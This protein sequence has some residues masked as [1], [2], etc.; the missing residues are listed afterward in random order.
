MVTLSDDGTMEFRFYRPDATEM[1]VV[2]DFNGWHRGALP[3]T[4]ESGGYW[5]CRVMLPAGLYHFRY[6]A[7]DQ[8]YVDYAAFGVECGPY[9]HD[10]TL[11]VE[12]TRM[13]CP[14][15]VDR[16][17]TLPGTPQTASGTQEEDARRSSHTSAISPIRRGLKR[18][19]PPS[20]S[21]AYPE[22]SVMCTQR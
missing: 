8:W 4:R 9:G 14:A 12:R 16:L 5:S 3:M 1:C 6:R 2:G 11:K 22:S 17:A 13:T 15:T 7:G 10:S 20:P 21:C 18:G 19:T